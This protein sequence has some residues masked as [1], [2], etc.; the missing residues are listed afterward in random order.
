MYIYI[1][2]TFS[3]ARRTGS[4]KKPRSSYP[5]AVVNETHYAHTP[6][7]KKKKKMGQISK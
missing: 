6:P 1:Q 2:S 5:R 7:P 3:R 4:V